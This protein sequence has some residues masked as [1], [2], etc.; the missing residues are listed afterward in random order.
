MRGEG[1]EYT[2]RNFL[3]R[4]NIF[5]KINWTKEIIKIATEQIIWDIS[6]EKIDYFEMKLSLDKYVKHLSIPPEDVVRIFYDYLTEE[7]EKWDIRFGIILALKYEADK[8]KQLRFSKI[9]EDP[10]THKLVVGID[11]VGD[12]AAFDVNFYEPI[13]K[14]WKDTGKG[15]EAHVGESQTAENVAKAI[16]I[17][18]VDRIAHGIKIVDHPEIIKLVLD[19]DVCL[20]IALTSN[21]Q[22]GIIS[23]LKAHPIKRLLDAGVPITIGTDDPAILN[24]TLD[25]E[26]ALLQENFEISEKELF[27]VMYNSIKYAF[28]DLRANR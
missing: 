19:N 22:T 12:E 23:T 26:Y 4:F 7:T 17:L 9:I 6:S 15:L 20:D 14:A 21:L 24:T 16:N 5:D 10:D 1:Q 25:K 3:D 11:L 18:H 13:F 2:F 27:D 28:T 8:E